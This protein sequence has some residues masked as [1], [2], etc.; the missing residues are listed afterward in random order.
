MNIMSLFYEFA[1]SIYLYILLC[2]TDFQ[3]E[4]RMRDAQGMG[5]LIVLSIVVSINFARSVIA[6]VIAIK[7]KI[8]KICY[9]K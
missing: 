6:S 7:G 2:L 9:K 4:N 3:G 5:L 1:N 8:E